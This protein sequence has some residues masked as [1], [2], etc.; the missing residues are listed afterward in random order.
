MIARGGEARLS[1]RHGVIE[2]LPS[3]YERWYWDSSWI[4]VGVRVLGEWV[5]CLKG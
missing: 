4:F 1:P 2:P 5:Q 3:S